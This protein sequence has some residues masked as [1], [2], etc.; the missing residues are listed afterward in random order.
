M[1]EMKKNKYASQN[2]WLKEN[3]KIIALKYAGADL[4]KY[5]KLKKIA[6]LRGVSFSRLFK[7]ETE[8]LL[9]LPEYKD[10]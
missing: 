7:D 9:E 1:Q 5:E 2:E 8:K 10:L 6:E 3:S 4:V